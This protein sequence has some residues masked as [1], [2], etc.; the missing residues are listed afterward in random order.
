MPACKSIYSSV[1]EGMRNFRTRRLS[2]VD[3]YYYYTIGC[4]EVGIYV[5]IYTTVL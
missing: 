4:L 3:I 5:F 2:M 1:V